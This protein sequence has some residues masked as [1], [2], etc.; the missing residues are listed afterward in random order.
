MKKITLILV[1]MCTSF[2]VSAW[3]A[4]GGVIYNSTIVAD[5]KIA[6]GILPQGHMGSRSPNIAANASV[7]GIVFKFTGGVAQG[8]TSGWR[9]ATTPG[10]RCEGWGAGG[11]DTFGSN[12]HGRAN[13]SSGGISNITVKSFVK[14][15]TS[16]VSTVWIN[17][18]RGDPVLEVIHRF[19]PAAI[20]PDTL[21]Q[22]LVTITNIGSSTIEDVRYTRAM[23]WDIPPTEYSELVTIVGVASSV[24]SATTPKVHDSGNNG[25]MVP[26]PFSGHVGANRKK[27]VHQAG[28]SDH[29]FV[30]T[31]KLGDLICGEAHT[32]MI[33]YGAAVDAATVK[34]AF[35][36]EDVPLYSIGEPNNKALKASASGRTTST[37]A[38]GFGFKGVSGSA[39]APSL[40]V[41]TAILPG[42]VDT[43][44]SIV[45]T[46]APPAIF[47][48][49]LF[50]AV[51]KYKQDKQWE[52]DILKYQLNTDGSLM[53]DI[54]PVKAL[55]I[56]KARLTA[57]TLS[58]SYIEGGR[59]IWTVGND[60]NC[61]GGTFAKPANNNNFVLG[62]VSKLQK[63]LYNC[64]GSA[65]QAQNLIKF[66]RGYDVHREDAANV[67]SPRNSL[68]GDT[69]HSEIVYVG[70]PRG[71]YSDDASNFGK[72]E[73]YHRYLKDYATF[74]GAHKLRRPQIYVGANDGM[75]HA[76]DENL[77]ERWAFIPPPVLTK[78]QGMLGVVGGSAGTGKSNSMFSVDGPIMVKDVY[79]EATDTWK[80]VLLGGLGYG[81][82]GYYALDI[83]DA[84]KPKHMF[85]FEN[86][87]TNKKVIY[88]DASG[89]KSSYPYLSAPTHIDYQK[90]G[91]TWSRPI[92]MLL[93]YKVG[94][95]VE[96]Q[97]W[98]AAFG[99][100]YGGGASSG[101]GPYVFVIDFEPK[102]GVTP[103]ST[104]GHILSSIKVTDDA[105]STI[106][107][108]VTA[109]LSAV[110]ADATSLANYYGGVAYFTDL[111]GQLWKYNLS[112]TSLDT[113]NTDLFSLDKAFRAEGTL[114]NDR[115]G[116]N[117]VATTVVKDGFG[118]SNIFN[119]FGTGDQSRIQRRISTINN[120][121]YG[122]KDSD[123][124]SVGLATSV[125]NR[126]VST[127]LNI[128][129]VECS[130]TDTMNWYSNV[131]SKTDLA[132]SKDSDYQKV[133]GRAG[134]YKK[135]LFFS[136][137]RP[138][139][140]ACPRTG[141]SEIVE[142]SDGCGA[143]THHPVGSGLVTSP[144]IDNRGNIYAGVSNLPVGKE[145]GG[146]GIDNIAKI[147][148]AT[149]GLGGVDIKS[150]KEIIY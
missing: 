9:D 150:W 104:G 114:Y 21:F 147:G 128:D 109:H 142:L 118:N 78:L 94:G 14:E 90:L 82:K 17:N 49:N 15:A 91:D 66:V 92:I 44:E 99:G 84:D 93:P 46:Y 67:N 29:G 52:G 56:L 125:A 34:A 130:I 120:R 83:T 97:R 10:C 33:Y 126:D 37:V 13:I 115:F 26:N 121:I 143:V 50:Q 22:G 113:A 88:W 4:G 18:S 72:S 69:F 1:L 145:I 117:Q 89:N 73:A 47:G 54:A 86:D 25:F 7:T 41:K 77:H 55:T 6:L 28:P 30:S 133:I 135:S 123:F 64:G 60:I 57:A 148:T 103:V 43:V 129:A 16:L 42:G 116:F 24:A 105:S 146:S 132:P 61:P 65:A 137:Y 139:D 110:T 124:P 79:I 111:Q 101:F 85:S 8:H 138:A 76:F 81:G 12:F 23:D 35:I 140:A 149:E 80:T 38:Y 134:L 31:F 45:Q 19:G 27:D 96:K 20:E 62:N 107:N 36:S 75:L 127:A 87:D 119:Y 39:I 108:G 59:S 95:E 102:T 5:Q 58:K 11:K 32:F 63:L 106:P 144:V 2:S 40:P 53:T 100:G 3:D 112:K 68:L 122:I 51:F 131:W 70:A 71:G 74:S 136:V 141:K 48:R 98:V